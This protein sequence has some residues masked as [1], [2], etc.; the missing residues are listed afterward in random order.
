MIQNVKSHKTGTSTT[1]QYNTI[2]QLGLENIGF[3]MR[4]PDGNCSIEML[5]HTQNSYN[6]KIQTVK[7][8]EL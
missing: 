4:L 6:I 5:S 1:V 7:I 8:T 3:Q 2:L